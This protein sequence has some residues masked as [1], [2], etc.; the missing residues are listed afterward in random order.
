LAKWSPVI[1]QFR[2]H[3]NSAKLPVARIIFGARSQAMRFL[4]NGPKFPDELLTARDEGQVL[5]FCGAGVSRAR[6]DLPDFYGLAERVVDAMRAAPDSP[7]RRLIKAA[8]TMEPIA[9]VGGLLPADR[10]FALLEREF[11]VRDVRAKVA[12]ALRPAA[13]VDLTAHRT[14]LDLARGPTSAIRLVTTNFDL[15]FEACDGALARFGPPRLPDPRRPA[16]FKGVMHLHGHVTEGYDGAQD[17]EFVLSSADFGRAYLADGWATRFMRG[18]IDRYRLVFIGYAADDPPIQYLLEALNRDEEERG[19]LY[20]FQSG[21]DDVATALW[22]H[23]GVRA[24]AYEPGET[25]EDL[26]RSLAAWAERARDPDAWQSKLLA[27]AKAGPTPL[28]PFERGQ[29]KHL[30]STAAGAHAFAQAAPGAEWLCTF[31]PSV[32]Y[33]TPQKAGH[34]PLMDPFVAYG[35]DDD[36]PLP[37]ADPDT[38]GRARAIPADAWDAFT[39]NTGDLTA[40]DPGSLGRLRGVRA[41]GMP[42]RVFRLGVWL[43]QVC[44]DPAAVWWA[45]RSGGLHP[46]VQFRIRR[47]LQELPGPVGP[48]E[49]AWR[50]ALRSW[51]HPPKGDLGGMELAVEVS[52][53]GWTSTTVRAW[54]SLVRPFVTLARPIL[55]DRPPPAGPDLRL[56]A[57]VSLDVE[58][59]QYEPAAA[60][61]D[62]LL[63]LATAELRRNLQI[64]ID[65]EIEISGFE[66]LPLPPIAVDPNVD[67]IFSRSHGMA[68]PFFEY[69]SL[70]DRLATV[71]KAALR[72]EAAAWPKAGAA[73]A[74]LRIWAAGRVDLS[75]PAE[76]ARTL[77]GLTRS[78]FWDGGNQRDLLLVLSQ[79]WGDMPASLRQRL[80]SRLLAGPLLGTGPRV[81]RRERRAHRMLARLIWLQNQGCVFSIDLEPTLAALRAEA[82][83]WKDAYATGAAAS[84]ETNAGFVERD[85]ST[86]GLEDEPPANLLRRAAELAGHDFGAKTERVPLAGL[87]ESRPAKLLRS[88]VLAAGRGEVHIDAWETL[89]QSQAR[90]TDRLRLVCAIGHRL[91]RLTDAQFSGLIYPISEWMLRLAQRLQT[92]LPD[93]FATLWTRALATIGADPEVVDSS[94]SERNGY[95]WATHALNSPTGKLTQALFSDPRAQMDQIP[96]GWLA[97][98]DALLDLGGTP[99]RDTVVFLAHHLA[100]LHYRAPEWTVARVV[101]VLGGDAEDERAFWSGF[102]WAAAFP[103]YALYR[104]IKPHLLALAVEPAKRSS[105]F[106]VAVSL[107]LGGWANVDEA[108]GEAT[109]SDGELREALRAGDSDFRHRI[110]WQLKAWTPGEGGEWRGNALRLLR[111]VWP[112]ELVVRSPRLSEDL[113]DLALAAGGDFPAFVDAVVPLMTTLDKNAH[114]LLPLTLADNK[115]DALDPMSLLKLVYAA[116]AEDVGEWSWGAEVVV[117]RLAQNAETVQDE[118]TLQLR[119]RLASR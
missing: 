49:T 14:L 83:R 85:P 109:V 111:N 118:R 29:V 100:Y 39:P 28:A 58:Y 11:R 66:G 52:H 4:A 30:V 74:R 65:L 41:S 48:V 63:P 44:D 45:A 35:L 17:D 46:D 105:H 21:D 40:S 26:W 110:L 82:P 55:S 34:G 59:P 31:D 69:V 114:C 116:L 12:E 15:L 87:A 90:S 95:D 91:A 92:D 22:K 107:V 67:G 76:A 10:V 98:V 38:Y 54:S 43:S 27:S 102:L 37:P 99:R 113:F 78:A 75:S 20:A 89:L 32:R 24:I 97:R 81:E 9:G 50:W 57:L 1:W 93:L 18:L 103:G 73:F 61:P 79:R 72:S 77:L 5:F 64:G 94:I 2:F 96:A 3:P 88:L 8:K 115:A 56:S 51:A 19:D 119:R 112:R 62:A 68:A 33:G 104:L 13:T 16:D 117:E 23:K 53:T 25:H 101:G 42:T 80:E 86:R 84:T 7:A 47:R 6:A 60:F 36:L 71:D 70:L 108:T 106:E